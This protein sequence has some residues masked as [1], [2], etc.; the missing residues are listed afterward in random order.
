MVTARENVTSRL[1]KWRFN[2]LCMCSFQEPELSELV[3]S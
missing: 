2:I 3:F 1:G